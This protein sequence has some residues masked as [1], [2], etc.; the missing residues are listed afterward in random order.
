LQRGKNPAVDLR[1]FVYRNVVLAKGK[2]VHIGVERKK[3]VR[4]T[5]P[6]PVLER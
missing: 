6:P 4:A 1:P 5:L 2:P 3:L